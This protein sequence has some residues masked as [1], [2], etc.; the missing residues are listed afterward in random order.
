M[1][2]TSDEAWHELNQPDNPYLNAKQLEV[3]NYLYQ[4]GAMIGVDLDRR[5]SPTSH[6]SHKRLS[7]LEALGL[8]TATGDAKDSK[9]DKRGFLW[10]VVKGF[11]PPTKKQRAA[12]LRAAQAAAGTLHPGPAALVQFVSNVDNLRIKAG[13]PVMS[14]T[15]DKV[16]AWLKAGGQS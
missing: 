9:T 7:E 10:G 13:S 6:S 12:T 4:H 15:F 1:P 11:V 5:L 14:T 2:W 3:Y 8:A 16:L